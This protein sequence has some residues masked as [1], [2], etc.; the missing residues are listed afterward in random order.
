[1][2]RIDGKQLKKIARRWIEF[3]LRRCR[4]HHPEIERVA[5]EFGLHDERL[6]FLNRVVSQKSFL[7]R[8]QDVLVF[9]AEI[10]ARR[11][12]E[13]RNERDT[14]KCSQHQSAFFRVEL[15]GKVSSPCSPFRRPM[16][17]S[18]SAASRPFRFQ[19]ATRPFQRPQE[20]TY[21]P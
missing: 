13:I 21:P 11:I 8:L 7:R 6:H 14:R 16:S 20:S 9:R 19:K 3:R 2:N 10:A 15:H 1:E 12:G 17:R 4:D 18:E 5:F